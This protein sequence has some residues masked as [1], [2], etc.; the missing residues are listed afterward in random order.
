M[1]RTVSE[2][3][4]AKCSFWFRFYLHAAMARAGLGD[5]YLDMLADWRGMLA[6]GMTTWAERAEGSTNSSRSDCHA[7]SASPNIDLFR[8]VLGIEPMAPGYAQ[9]R[10]KPHPCSLSRASGSV[11]HPKGE[12]A[13]EWVKENDRLRAEVRL[14][15]GVT[16]E[17]EWAGRVTPLHAGRNVL[18]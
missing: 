17:F 10:V 18:A 6:K 9:V 1:E 16:G 7:W 2:P 5:R 11:P 8:I 3:G 4:L 15:E 13:V 14:P 12:V